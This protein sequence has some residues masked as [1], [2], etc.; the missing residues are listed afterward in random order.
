M[1][2]SQPRRLTRSRD[3]MLAGV[4]GGLADYFSLDPTIVR[5]L[6]V[7]SAFVSF[8]TAILGYIILAIVLPPAGSGSEPRSGG[9]ASIDDPAARAAGLSDS[10]GMDGGVIVGLVLVAVGFLVLFNGFEMLRWFGWRLFDF[11]WPAILITAG[12]ALIFMRRD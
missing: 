10:R 4:A 5:I 11:W 7:I 2:N 1:Q 12:L 9:G 8:G 6:F 3:Q